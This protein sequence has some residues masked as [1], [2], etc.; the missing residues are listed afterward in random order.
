MPEILLICYY[1]CLQQIDINFDRTETILAK[2]Q[3]NTF[4]TSQNLKQA[5]QIC[6]VSIFH[7]MTL[8]HSETLTE[9]SIEYRVNTI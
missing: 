8:I 4:A 7:D 2:I 5:S 6:L 9:N 1:I 3:Q